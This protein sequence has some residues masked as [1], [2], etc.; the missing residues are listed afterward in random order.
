MTAAEVGLQEDADGIGGSVVVD[1]PGRGAVPALVLIAVHAG[2]AA[3]GA[4]VGLACARRFQRLDDRV[5]VDVVAV[6]V[7]EVAVPG[8]R[9]DREQPGVGEVRVVGVHPG[10]D[11]GVRDADRVRVGDRD[12]ALAGAGL[13]DPRDA[14]HLAVAVERV[15]AGR[16]RVARVGL[17]ARVDG[18]D[19][20][21]DVVALDQ[22]AV[23]DFDPGDVGDGVVGSGSAAELQADPAGAGL[24]GGG[25]Q[26]RVVL[27]V[28][29]V[30]VALVAL[31]VVGRRLRRRSVGAHGDQGNGSGCG[32]AETPL[33]FWVRVPLRSRATHALGTGML[34]PFH[35]AGCFGPRQPVGGLRGYGA[36]G[37]ASAW[38]AEGQG[39]ESP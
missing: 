13:F 39:F 16:H 11:A 27:L 8:L 36:A 12:R 9:R 23:A 26:M 6:D 22:G 24:A 17:A 31:V 3:D 21:P 33:R 4:L 28:L 19:S 2:A 38:H 7:V 15:I 5:L 30:L 10:D 18:G 29:A 25:G 34:T 20:G 14:G 32:A 35:L 37:S 1:Q